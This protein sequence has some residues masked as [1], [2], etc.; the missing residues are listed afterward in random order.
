MT[1]LATY[2]LVFAT[3]F[4]SATIVPIGSDPVLSGTV[5]MSGQP[6][7]A[8]V[9]VATIGNTLGAIVNW[10][11]GMGIERFRHKSWFPAS[12]AQLAKA[13]THYDRWGRWTLLF[14]WLPLIGDAFTVLAGVMKEKLWIFVVLVGI[15]KLFRY[16]LLVTGTVFFLF[17]F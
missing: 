16:L 10:A 11:L 12:D 7:W 5:A 9:A 1:A 8:L 2:L 13:K 14:A 4:L 15:G 6:I 17:G 3:S